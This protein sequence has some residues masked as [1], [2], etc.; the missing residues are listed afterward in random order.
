MLLEKILDS[1]KYV[2][3]NSSYVKI[4]YE[5]LDDFCKDINIDTTHYLS[6]NPFNILDLDTKDIIK[7]LMYYHSVGF[8]Y[9]GNPKW[10]VVI[11]D[12]EYDGAYAMLYSL[13]NTFKSGIK[14]VDED[15]FKT[16]VKSD[17]EIPLIDKRIRNI[18]L[19]NNYFENNDFYNDISNINIDKDLFLYIIN[20]F[21]YLEDESIYKDK[22]VYFYK[23]AQL[24][25]SDILH[26]MNIK[27]NKEIDCSNIIGCADYKIPQVLRG[28]DILEFNNELSSL[29][30]SGTV[31]EK[32]SDMEIEIRA[33][34]LVVIDYIYN[35]LNKKYE[36]IY[37][38]DYI[39]LQGQDKNKIN[40]L[41]HLTKTSKY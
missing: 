22:E 36:R 12:R 7:L 37:I 41:Y 34:T 5:K 13:V 17:N 24:L 40:N 21:S 16:I 33:N 39:W 27:E 2:N 38:N 28:L 23:L 20:N 35:K 31:L 11:D 1:S 8:C 26:I 9:W 30:D 3:S 25:T 15:M 18:K 6:F 14:I 32:D 10:N 19:L 29:V 4:N